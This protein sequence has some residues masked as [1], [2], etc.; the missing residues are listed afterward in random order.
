MVR[1]AIAGGGIGGLTAALALRQFGFEA[2]VYE[3]APALLDV[4]AAIAIWPNAMRVLERLG[5]GTM[6]REHAGEMAEI[7]WLDQRGNLLN[8]VSIANA[9]AL[10]RADLQSTLL[11]ALPEQNIR[12]GKRL[13]AYETRKDKVVARFATGEKIEADFLV[14]AD[15]IHSQVRAQLLGNDEPIYRGY[16][17]WR[18]IASEAPPAIPPNAAIEVH[19]RGQ[20]FGIG[21]VGAGRIGWWAA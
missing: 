8:R 7:R 1:I 9:V 5:L 18:G 11:H 21:P 13:L 20:R 14:G 19:G 16:T 12:L 10:H 2:E 17:V 4:G 15:G 6:I 3:Q